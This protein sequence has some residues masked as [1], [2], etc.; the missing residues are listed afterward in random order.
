MKH[1]TFPLR[2]LRI[3]DWSLH[4]LACKRDIGHQDLVFDPEIVSA[5]EKVPSSDSSYLTDWYRNNR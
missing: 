1:L 5:K 4:R 2:P 3:C